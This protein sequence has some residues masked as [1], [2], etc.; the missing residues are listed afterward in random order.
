M[1]VRVS[2][3]Y[4]CCVWVFFFIVECLCVLS[5]HFEGKEQQQKKNHFLSDYQEEKRANR[6]QNNEAVYC[7]S[8]GEHRTDD[9]STLANRIGYP[10]AVSPFNVTRIY[11][12]I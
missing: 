2:V 6:Y 10:M 7:L 11:I 12:S 3:L 5:H 4:Q 8:D 9:A 1:R